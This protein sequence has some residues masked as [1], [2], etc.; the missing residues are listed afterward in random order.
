MVGLFDNPQLLLFFIFS[1]IIIAGALGVVF[2]P[3]PITSA[4]LLVLAFFALS[5]IY[6]V[7]GSVFVATMQVFV[8]AGAIMVLVVF[9]L[10]LLS[11]HDESAFKLWTH[12]LKKGV[13]LFFVALL[14]VVLINSVR[15]GIPNT[16][17]SPHGY[18]K[19]GNYEYDITQNGATKSTK[20]E[21]NTAVVGT[22]MFLDYLLPFEILSI[23]L[24]TAVLGAVILGKKNLGKKPEEGEK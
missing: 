15:E 11:L 12:P 14:G 8:Y 23:L 19:T 17:S 1:G 10:M 24:L 4:I 13:L 5:G 18:S 3:N 21:G 9:V 6:A 7:L 2:H 16:R 20:V 22:S